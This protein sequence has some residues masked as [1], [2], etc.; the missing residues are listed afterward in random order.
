MFGINFWKNSFDNAAVKLWLGFQ[1]NRKGGEV[2]QTKRRELIG[3]RRTCAA[4]D[5]PAFTPLQ[6]AA[7]L[8]LPAR[9]N[10]HREGFTRQRA[11]VRLHKCQ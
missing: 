7:H 3:R 1:K 8:Q 2:V 5:S 6:R 10:G 11:L 9:K 4:H